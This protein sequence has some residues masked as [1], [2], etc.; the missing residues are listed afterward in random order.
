MCYESVTELFGTPLI[1]TGYPRVALHIQKRYS[2]CG[3]NH[4]IQVKEHFPVN[5]RLKNIVQ[6][7][8]SHHREK[9]WNSPPPIVVPRNSAYFEYLCNQ[10]RESVTFSS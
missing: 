9:I 2:K 3:S 8:A 7:V 6:Q 1:L 4:Y 5:P 10:L